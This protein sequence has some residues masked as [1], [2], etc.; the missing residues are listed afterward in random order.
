MAAAPEPRLP[1]ATPAQAPV[2]QARLL[3]CLCTIF[4][5]VALGV[6]ETRLVLAGARQRGQQQRRWQARRGARSW[7][8]RAQTVRTLPIYYKQHSCAALP[9]LFT[10]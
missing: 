2:L 7:G 3:L 5:P 9:C 6:P 8:E 10:G 4:G 1:A